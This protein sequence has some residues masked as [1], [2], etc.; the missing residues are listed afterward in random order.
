M[1]NKYPNSPF[2][3]KSSNLIRTTPP[4]LFN[5]NSHPQFL[6]PW[7]TSFHCWILFWT[8]PEQTARG[9]CQI[10]PILQ[11]FIRDRAETIGQ[12]KPHS[13]L[14]IIQHTYGASGSLLY[15][16]S[17][18]GCSGIPSF[19]ALWQSSP[20]YYHL[21]EQIM[22]LFFLSCPWHCLS[23][24]PNP[25]R[26]AVQYPSMYPPYSGCFGCACCCWCYIHSTGNDKSNV[27]TVAS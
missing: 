20:R 3:Y 14:L 1:F 18:S 26:L 16:N 23:G 10:L 4:P 22:E 12:E 25:T 24:E 27:H 21:L 7:S 2:S 8:Y 19:S 9:R 11:S 13:P 6:L 15:S 17:S 5:F